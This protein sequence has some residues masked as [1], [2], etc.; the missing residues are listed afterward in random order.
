MYFEGLSN[1]LRLLFFKMNC[2]NIQ[3]IGGEYEY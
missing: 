1:N 3:T 2:S